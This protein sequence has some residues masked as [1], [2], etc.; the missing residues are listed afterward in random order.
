MTKFLEG[1]TVRVKVTAFGDSD[2]ARDIE[3]RGQAAELLEDMGATDDGDD[4][5]WRAFVDVTCDEVYL[6]GSELEPLGVQP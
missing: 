3:N 6:L 2:E 4:S 1:Q 5:M